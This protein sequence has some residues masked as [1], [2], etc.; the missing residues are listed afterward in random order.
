M[1]LFLAGACQ[2]LS[3]KREVDYRSRIW[4]LTDLV[5]SLGLKKSHATAFVDKYEGYLIQDPYYMEMYQ[6]GLNAMEAH[7]QNQED[8]VTCLQE[9]LR[10]WDQSERT[11]EEKET[12][13][14]ASYQNFSSQNNVDF[15]SV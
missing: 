3:D 8:A 9:A 13:N 12:N 6:A 1:N 4:I 14:F 11:L 5:Q 15:Q 7:L 10:K 2:K